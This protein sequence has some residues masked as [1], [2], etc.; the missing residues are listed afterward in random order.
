MSNIQAPDQPLPRRYL[1]SILFLAD[2]M[3]SADGAVLGAEEHIVHSLAD[4][5]NMTDYRQ[6]NDFRVLSDQK[7]CS[8]LDTDAAKTGALVVISLVLKADSE[9]PP[10]KRE[11]FSKIR[12]LLDAEPVTVPQDLDAHKKLAMKYLA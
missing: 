9:R 3:S 12:Q 7:A 5:A 10:E 1:Q 11:F 6:D 8:A 4:A 2:R